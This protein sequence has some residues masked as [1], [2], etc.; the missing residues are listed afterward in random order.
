MAAFHFSCQKGVPILMPVVARS[1]SRRYVY[2]PRMTSRQLSD[3]MFRLD[4]T[5]GQL[6]RLSG[7]GMVRLNRCL[8]GEDVPVTLQAMLYVWER[9]PRALSLARQFAD[10]HA[11]DVRDDE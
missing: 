2:E 10:E 1:M 11:R 8:K 3:A 5:T 4:L 6:A 7:M 9:E